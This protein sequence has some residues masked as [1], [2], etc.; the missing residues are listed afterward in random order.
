MKQ[1]VL[2]AASQPLAA[3]GLEAILSAEDDFRVVRT[4]DGL[5]RLELVVAETPADVLV[6]DLDGPPHPADLLMRLKHRRPQLKIIAV[7]T[8]D[9]ASIRALF[10][11]GVDGYHLDPSSAANLA[12]GVRH[13]LSALKFRQSGAEASQERLT[14]Q[15][16]PTCDVFTCGAPG[17]GGASSTAEVIER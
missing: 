5:D 3:R 15:D 11:L 2:V 8:A 4:I 6:V 7:G 16:F 14:V 10:D 12:A 13:L 9:L 17:V 1:H